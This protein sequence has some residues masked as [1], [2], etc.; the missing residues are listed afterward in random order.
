MTKKSKTPSRKR[1]KIVEVVEEK[2][3]ED[4]DVDITGADDDAE[5]PQA[6]DDDE[7]PRKKRKQ[8]S[9]KNVPRNKVTNLRVVTSA[10]C[11]TT[12]QI[13][14]NGKWHELVEVCNIIVCVSECVCV[15]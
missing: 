5:A 2:D 13:K 4:E 9:D 1:Q 15:V 10:S 6:D 14:Y 8:R 7:P 11:V 3:Q 12:R